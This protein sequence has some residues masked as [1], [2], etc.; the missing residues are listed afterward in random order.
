[1]TKLSEPDFLGVVTNTPLVSI[2][3]LVRDAQGRYLLGRRVNRPAQGSWFVPGGRIRKN[4]R[5]DAAFARLAKEEL[6]ISTL[7]RG[8]AALMGVYEHFYRDNFSGVDGI[9]T[10]YVVLGYRVL[11]ALD[12]P[13][14][15]VDQ[16]SD[17]RWATPAE[18][19]EDDTVDPHNRA[20]FEHLDVAEAV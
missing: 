12:L 2:D 1:M 15:P 11:N 3:L 18:V 8:D 4:E 19:L 7:T 13:H 10:H 14:L 6:G 5:L 9:G 16:H 20:Y 17:Y